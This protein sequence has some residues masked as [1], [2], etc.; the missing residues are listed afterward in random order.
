MTTRL[1]DFYARRGWAILL[2]AAFLLPLTINS[3]R[4]ALKNHTNDVRTWLPQEYEETTTYAWFRR[5]FA[6]DEFVVITWPGCHADDPRL[7]RLPH[8]LV[9]QEGQP[10]KD[11]RREFFASVV[12]GPQVLDRL[13]DAP[14]NLTREEAV[15][16][17][18]GTLFGADGEQTCAILTLHDASKRHLRTTIK[19]LR[20][21]VTQ[22]CGV[23]P[24]ELRL[25]GPPAVNAAIDTTSNKSLLELAGLS[26]IVGLFIAW[27]CFKT[28]RMTW[29]VFATGAYSALASL[30][31]VGLTPVPMNAILISMGPL[32]YVA[33][34]SGAIHMANYY[35]DSVR[36]RG[37]A[38]A[39][40]RAVS[41]A[42]VPLALATTT[43]AVGLLS[44]CYSELSPIRMFGLFS[45]IG[46]AVSG[47]LLFFVLPS[48]LEI[49]RPGDGRTAHASGS[50]G[51]LHVEGE[52]MLSPRWQRF[53]AGVTSHSGLLTLA[54]LAILAVCGL[55]LSR[56]E[57]SIK[58]LRFF[59]RSS[60]IVQTYDWMEANLGDLVPM[61]VVLRID[62]SACKLDLLERMELV[63]RVQ[64]ALA[65]LDV[66]G[67]TLSAATF[68]PEMP[69]NKA[70]PEPAA[71]TPR[72]SVTAKKLER[73]YDRLLET[74]FL[75]LGEGEELWR[76]SARVSARA[77][78]DYGIVAQRMKAAV[79][80]VLAAQ[81]EHAQ[82]VSAVYTG[83]IPIVYKAQQ[84]LLDGMLFGFGTDVALIVVAI[85]VLL[86]HWSPGAMLLLTSL[87]PTTVIFG[88]LGWSSIL[89]DI[90]TVI[91]PSVAL[92]VTVDDVVHFL[93]WF[94]RGIERGLDRRQSV[95]LAY[96]GCARAMYQ[97]WGVI[98]LGL[99]MFALSS[100]TPTMRFGSL[101]VALLTLGLV[102]NLI[103]LP[104]L[105]SGP[106]GGF[107]ER[108]IRRRM[109][110]Q[111]ADKAPSGTCESPASAQ[112]EQR[113]SAAG[114]IYPRRRSVQT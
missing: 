52:D 13:M 10:V 19:L 61:E 99:A 103:F 56:L 72:R 18:R 63:N 8:T 41:H 105:L 96:Q 59:P 22:E 94:K 80:P 112:E 2:A 26:G 113:T 101:M 71:Y 34:T 91:T 74:G 100:F 6:N 21:I 64:Q 46:V 25:G 55:G 15:Q 87:F 75:A 86:R 92:G 5:H 93:L 73:N 49:V 51:D 37:V 70:W 110:A 54:G 16:R 1:S 78:L 7:E 23:A 108:A 107:L 36:D 109:H 67:S 47:L 50:R 85:V 83:M 38:G 82:G 57:T 68:A 58:V 89:V 12:T 65:D 77:N 9:P 39:A 66:V 45:A 42:W 48:L 106:L 28:W 31:V 76:L 29:I 62:E 3:A 97:S 95:V 98:G 79:E 102:G 60:E 4:L 14:A 17:L 114:P 30:A 11:Q 32:V 43:T 35:R 104:A 27:R 44:L 53:A 33:T 81:R 88:V 24:E 111:P 40:G 69:T 20:G 90:G 84:S